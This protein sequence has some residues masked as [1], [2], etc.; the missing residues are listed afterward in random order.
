[1]NVM[2]LCHTLKPFLASALLSTLVLQAGLSHADDT[3]IF[4]GGPTIDDNVRPNVL[5]V[6]DNSGSMAWRLDSDETASSGQKSRMMVLKESFADIL[7]NTSDINI[8]VMVLNARTEYGSSRYMFPV[9]NIDDTLGGGVELSGG[10]AGILQSADDASQ[11]ISPAGDAVID[12]PILLM[13]STALVGNIP[14]RI[15]S[16]L[17]SANSFFRH[18]HMT[19]KG[20]NQVTTEYACRMDPPSRS[21]DDYCNNDELSEI[22]LQRNTSSQALF[23]FEDL[24]LPAN[25]I[26]TSAYIDITPTNTPNSSSR[27]SLKLD[28]T[29]ENS[30]T[31]GRL[32]DNNTFGGRT[33]QDTAVVPVNG[34]SDGARV[35]I[36][37]LDQVKA[38]LAAAPT[39]NPVQ[40]LFVRISG[41]SDNYYSQKYAFCANDCPSGEAPTLVIEYG[42][43]GNGTETEQRM[44]ALRFQ[45]VSIPRGATISSAHISFVPAASNSEPATFEVRAERTGDASQ[46]AAGSNLAGRSKTT[47][48][49]TWAAEAWETENPP[50]PVQ[51]PDVTQLVQE[52]VNLPTWCGN[53]AMAFH[54]TPTSGTGL[55]SAHSF[56]GAGGLQ[57]ILNVSYTGGE[58]GCMQDIVEVRITDQKNDAYQNSSGQVTLGDLQLPLS[59]NRIGARFEDLPISRDAEVVEAKVIIT[60]A[61]TVADQTQSIAI[62]FQNSANP[63]AFSAS[64]SNLSSNRTLFSASNCTISGGW[65][66][67]V[68]VSCD[69]DSTALNSI[70]AKSSWYRGNPLNLFLVQ[71]SD[72][73]LKVKAY[74]D[75]PAQS[76]KLRL[77]LRNGGSSVTVRQH[78]NSL[79]QSMTASGN[80][81]IVPTLYDAATYYRGDV[82]GRAS[83]IDSA[84]QAN[85]LVLLTDGQAN[86]NT[87]TTSIANLIGRTC[88]GDA[89]DTDEK[90]ARSLTKWLADNDQS[91][92]IEGDNLITTHTVGFALDASG[93]STSAQVKKFLSDLAT[94]GGG[95]AY[96]AESA[97]ELSAAFNR[98]IQEVLATNTTFVNA[99]APINSFNRQDNKDQL[100]FA[101][102]R[103]S[104]RDRWAGN[105]KRYRMKI[106]D[107]V[108]TI[109]D[110]DGV[111]AIDPNTGFFRDNARSFWTS[112]RDGSDVT[113]GGAAHKLP[114]PTSRKLYTYHGNSPASPVALSNYPIST[115]NSRLT[116][117]LLG[118]S[119]DDKEELLD[120]IRGL[121]SE[122]NPRKGLGDPI[123]SSPRL[124]TYR[125]ES[126]SGDECVDEDQAAIMGT[127]EGFIHLFDTDTGKEHFAFM[128][129][130]LLPNIKYLQDNAKSTSQKPRRYG[131]DNTVALWVNDANNNGVIYG[132]KNPET[133]ATIS[134]KNSGE[135]VYA[136][137]TMGRGGRNI[138][139]LDITDRD[140][141]KLLWQII[142]GSTSGFEHLGQTWSVPV[143]A[144][145]QVGSNVRDVL[146]FGGGYDPS[147][148]DLNSSDSTRTADG[149]G[150]AI[151]IVDAKT[152]AKIWSAGS[153]DSHDLQLAK[154]QYSIPSKVR[155]IDIQAQSA[156][157]VDEDS[158]R[159]EAG[160]VLVH[161]TEKLADQIFVGDM[162]G[163]IWRFFINHGSSGANLVTAGG[164]SGNG[165]FASV[166]GDTPATARRFYHEPDVSL[167][168]VGSTPTLTVNIGSGYRGHPLNKFIDDR[169]YSFRT[170]IL[171]KNGNEGTL[172]E[173]DMYDATQNLIQAGN[174][175]QQ[176]TARTAFA[177]THGGWYITLKGDG[178][179]VL[180][181]ALTAG[182][183]VY[184]NTYEPTTGRGVCS[185]S[186][187]KNRAYSVRLANAT[188]TSVPLDGNGSYEDRYQDSNSGG[189]SSDPQLFCQG[190]KCFVL[191]DPSVSPTAVT[192]PPLGKTYWMDETSD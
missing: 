19:G 134:G 114:T 67:G 190:D 143:K 17:T 53:N 13:G 28:V 182:G 9:R 25:A 23:R 166:G 129:E 115:S 127:N 1:M 83:P 177:E 135:F 104:D 191:P 123:H 164:S 95:S 18:L 122:G 167:L 43:P 84:C 74:E 46:F 69:V 12:D 106:E 24:N 189:I 174:A 27:R 36:D 121:D 108:A 147:Q 170:D 155:V 41:N 110:A 56:D 144:R 178:E 92:T 6:L 188:P 35:A 91:A 172:T 138:Y 49:T 112:E 137:A 151:Y 173:G 88:T 44:A 52:V 125:C 162:G 96:T 51:G 186:I 119:E 78:L 150:N 179:K 81:P 7:N 116:P 64:T 68:P 59:P 21:N 132:G 8:G 57:P 10:N 105:L 72:S 128:P 26:V 158:G 70:F 176:A 149:M 16:A 146:I 33:Y 97:G 171:F 76:I 63:S 192:T 93:A 60:P 101:L 126:Y 165:V 20:K 159:L 54:I 109:V 163:Q 175:G 139:A 45:E 29:V 32:N 61:N 55:R 156:T 107:G 103:P 5:F 22:N 185:A 118:V 120:Y 187:G 34:W 157:Q 111:S 71:S 40:G 14:G 181:R 161:D 75:N 183:S 85:H 50:V 169:F 100:Y 3:E 130:A 79:V 66:A 94:N 73:D 131:M 168:K 30:K 47:A 89:T 153:D 113:L 140:S 62:R 152:G 37:L 87:A 4:F 65:R 99:S 124:V 39:A 80:T 82:A 117:E 11:R 145:I 133:G 102:F 160:G 141:P 154:M 31:P 90:C 42:T 86:S 180:S 98:I 142:G 77:K 15:S 38:L 2:N 184:F 148:D 48:V 58:D 136:Y